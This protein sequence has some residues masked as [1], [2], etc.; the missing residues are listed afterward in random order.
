MTLTATDIRLSNFYYL[1]VRLLGVAAG[2]TGEAPRWAVGPQGATGMEVAAMMAGKGG[3]SETDKCMTEAIEGTATLTG[4]EAATATTTATA[5]QMTGDESI[6]AWMTRDALALDAA[7]AGR[8][9]TMATAA[10]VT[11]IRQSERASGH[12]REMNCLPETTNG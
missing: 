2:T 4:G 3:M 10:T 1:L 9:L 6:R 12:A 5:G 7:G 8:G 11:A